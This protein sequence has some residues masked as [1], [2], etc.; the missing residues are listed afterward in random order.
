MAPRDIDTLSVLQIGCGNFGPT[1]LAAWV[2]LGFADRLFVADPSPAKIRLSFANLR[3]LSCRSKGFKTRWMTRRPV[4]LS[5][6]KSRM[7]SCFPDDSAGSTKSIIAR[8][9]HSKS[10]SRNSD[11]T[12]T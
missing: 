7:P 3:K 2:Q 6:S 11:G 4:E 8:S 5:G 10:E 12:T 1:H 9:I